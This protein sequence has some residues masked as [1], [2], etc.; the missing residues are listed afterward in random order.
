M[1]KSLPL[2]AQTA[3]VDVRP[4]SKTARCRQVQ[5]LR[6]LWLFEGMMHCSPSSKI[7]GYQES[8]KGLRQANPIGSPAPLFPQESLV[9]GTPKRDVFTTATP[10]ATGNGPKQPPE[11]KGGAT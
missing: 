5:A 7:T 10:R 2:N 11:C 8:V 9:A 3:T 1:P 6:A 4:L